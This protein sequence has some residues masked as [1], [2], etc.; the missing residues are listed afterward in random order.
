MLLQKG[1]VGGHVGDGAGVGLVPGVHFELQ[2]VALGQQGDVFRG[3]VGDDGVKAVPE[4]VAVHAGAGQHLVFDE[5]VEF[6]GNLQAVAGGAFGHGKSFF[7]KSM[8][9]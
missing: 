4:L 2:A 1:A 7:K 5:T 6:G 8:G 3:Q 9:R